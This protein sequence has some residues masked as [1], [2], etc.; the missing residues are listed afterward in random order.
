MEMTE[1]VKIDIIDWS[2]QGIKLETIQV[3]IYAKYK[4]YLDT[5]VIERFKSVAA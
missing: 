4:F 2:T 5:E 3:L 1:R